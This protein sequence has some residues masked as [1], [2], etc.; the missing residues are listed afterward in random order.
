MEPGP[1]LDMGTMSEFALVGMA[2]IGAQRVEF[3]LYG[4]G[5][6]LVHLPEYSG[7]RFR[8]LEPEMFLRGDTDD[9]KETLGGL[10]QA[11][12]DNLLLNKEDISR[13][14]DHRNLIA[15]NYWR[16]TKANLK[17]GNRLENP[18]EFLVQFIDQC[19]HWEKVLK[20]L[21]TLARQEKAA[22][23]GDDMVLS[24]DE[25]ESADYYLEQV[26]TCRRA[27]TGPLPYCPTP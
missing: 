11:F 18:E 7:K 6:H 21:L 9:L 27:K 17:G 20:G 23:T 2:I 15:H 16:L 19:V 22:R 5:S 4:L 25:V 10:V 14:V 3:L 1:K 26:E 12:G 13:F 24:D 8:D